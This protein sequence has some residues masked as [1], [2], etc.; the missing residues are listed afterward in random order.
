MTKSGYMFLGLTAVV[1]ALASVL[2][3]TILRLFAAARNMARGGRDHAGGE[4]VFMT[5]AMEEALARLRLREQALAALLTEKTVEDAAAKAGIAYRTLKLWLTRPDFQADYRA[6]RAE[7]LDRTVAPGYSRIGYLLRR[8]RWRLEI[9]P[10]KGYLPWNATTQ[11]TFGSEGCS[12]AARACVRGL[13]L[14]ACR[15]TRRSC[16]NPRAVFFS[17]LRIKKGE[18]RTPHP[19]SNPLKTVQRITLMPMS[20]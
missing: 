5:A 2:A 16:R 14:S 17:R 18:T 7:I 13:T 11:P 9:R 12:S 4:T 6:A 15:S 20:C 8:P 19:A 10:C 1:G 3:F